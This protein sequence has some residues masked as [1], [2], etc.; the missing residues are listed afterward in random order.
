MTAGQPGSRRG[1]LGIA[2]LTCLALIG[3][4]LVGSGARP[5]IASSRAQLASQVGSLGKSPAAQALDGRVVSAV[6]GP[7]VATLRSG[8]KTTGAPESADV[9]IDG[10]EAGGPYGANVTMVFRTPAY[11]LAKDC[12]SAYCDYDLAGISGTLYGQGDSPSQ[13]CSFPVTPSIAQY[14]VHVGF[15]DVDFSNLVFGDPPGYGRLD[16]DLYEIRNAGGTCV[17]YFEAG[18]VAPRWV[19]GSQSSVWK[20]G[21]NEGNADITWNYALAPANTCSNPVYPPVGNSSTPD[22]CTPSNWDTDAVGGFTPGVEPLNVIIS[23][24]SNVSLDAIQEGMANWGTVTTGG[25]PLHCLSAEMANVTGTSVVQQ[26]SWRLGA[27]HGSCPLGNILSLSGNENHA[28][29]WDQP[30]PGTAGRTAWFISASYETL[31]VQKDGIMVPVLDNK[32]YAAA[33]PLL[34][35]HCIDGSQGSFDTDGY[36]RGAMDFVD[37]IQAGASR[38]GWNVTVRTD[39]SFAGTGEGGVPFNGTVSVVTVKKP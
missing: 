2:A 3:A 20:L 32:K 11:Y 8:L 16:V 21:D 29:I 15:G 36:N 12:S 34:I 24:Q 10:F 13:R 26:E 35:W 33:H 22:Y 25:P 4:V 7:S 27:A 30:M 31:C 19:P 37:A 5:A 6:T 9:T 38:M 39:P 23:A 18:A 1:G 28:R 17:T 14:L